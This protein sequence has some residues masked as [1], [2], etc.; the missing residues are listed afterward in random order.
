LLNL[1]YKNTPVRGTL[2]YPMIPGPR[3][4]CT[5]RKKQRKAPKRG[6]GRKKDGISIDFFM[7]VVYDIIAKQWNTC[8]KT[9]RYY[10]NK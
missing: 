7:Q 2:P 8:W 3:I 5:V 1:L 10:S 4:V 6:H 9:G